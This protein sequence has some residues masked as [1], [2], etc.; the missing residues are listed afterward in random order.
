MGTNYYARKYDENTCNVHQLH[1]GKSSGGWHFSLHI[2]REIDMYDNQVDEPILSLSDWLLIFD[3][4]RIFDE[5]DK[6]ITKEEMLD[7]IKNRGAHSDTV[8]TEQEASKCGG[9]IGYNNLVASKI[10]YNHCFGNEGGTWDLIG[11][12]FS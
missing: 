12:E 8:L 10:D 3:T 6:E 11:G 2:I 5:Y 4:Y 1:I 9:I 7:I